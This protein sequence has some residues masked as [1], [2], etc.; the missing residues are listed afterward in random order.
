MQ[1]IFTFKNYAVLLPVL[2][3]VIATLIHSLNLSGTFLSDD[4]TYLVNNAVITSI[5]PFDFSTLFL[6]TTNIWGEVLPFRDFLYVLQ[7]K[8]F[9][10]WATGYHLVSL[11]LFILT[12][13]ILFQLIFTL[14][15][16]HLPQTPLSKNGKQLAWLLTTILTTVFLFH[17]TYVEAFNFISGQKDALSMLFILWSVYFMYKAGRLGNNIVLYFIL[18]V[19]FHYIAVLSKLSALPSILF[20]PLLLLF[21]SNQSKKKIVIIIGCWFIAN[22]PVIIWFFHISA[23]AA[24]IQDVIATIPLL[25]RI[26]RS[27]NYVGLH[28]IHILKPWPLS[29]GY[30]ATI[31]W[32][33]NGNFLLGFLFLSVYS[34]VAFIKRNKLVLFGFFM[35]ILYLAPVLSIYPDIPNEKVYDRYLA[36]PFIGLLISLLPVLSKIL[37]KSLLWKKIT[38][39]FFAALAAILGFLTSLYVPVFQSGKSLMEHAY[40]YYPTRGSVALSLASY[41][42]GVNEYEKGYKILEKEK[43]ETGNPYHLIAYEGWHKFN[44]N[45]FLGAIQEFEKMVD[46]PYF[47]VNSKY[48]LARSYD[49][50]GNTKKALSYYFAAIQSRDID[51]V[52]YRH[53]SQLRFDALQKVAANELIKFQKI[54]DD[55]PGN[56]NAY[57]QLGVA[58][59]E[60]LQY[61]QAILTYEKILSLGGTNW[62]LYY[63]LGNIY[64]KTEDFEKA[65]EFYNKSILLNNQYADTYNNLGAALKKMEDYEGAIKA[66]KIAMELDPKSKDAAFNLGLLYHRIEDEEN[67][68]KYFTY[69]LTNFPEL[70]GVVTPYLEEL[71]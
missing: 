18:G 21:T 38:V 69:V 26:P 14:A 71:K 68:K 8:A 17:P 22:I 43:E 67:A 12:Y 4:E 62:A 15:K 30:P 5:S 55:N 28:L 10:N 48:C 49:K 35:F 51:L 50:I 47:L 45:D 27:L 2:L 61:K 33:I 1:R 60:Y 6:T 31:D 9:G 59:E 24:T 64:K 42:E 70:K 41:Y 56:L 20:I 19:L 36:I 44:N 65:I 16:N 29:L 58:Q 66:T 37:T 40:F 39:G 32:V 23:L 53:R 25:E 57:A 54:V 34:L 46:S 63:N 3:C 52:K 13:G 11:L 7:Y